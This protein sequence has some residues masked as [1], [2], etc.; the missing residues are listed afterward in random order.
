ML[1]GHLLL[2]RCLGDFDS[3]LIKS[4]FILSSLQ[5][6]S[7]HIGKMANHFVDALAKQGVD[8]DL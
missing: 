2:S 6:K 5:V 8:R 1:L 3:I 4:N 7:Q